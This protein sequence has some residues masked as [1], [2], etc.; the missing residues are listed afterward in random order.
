MRK[1]MVL[2][3]LVFLFL[4]SELLYSSTKLYSIQAPS[5]DVKFKLCNVLYEEDLVTGKIRKIGDLS[6]ANVY[7]VVNFVVNEELGKLFLT[8]YVTY[9]YKV[10]V[11]NLSPLQPIAVLNIETEEPDIELLSNTRNGNLYVTYWDD[12]EE[13]WT[14]KLYYAPDYLK[15]KE[16]DGCFILVKNSYFSD[17]G[18][19][20]FSI[21]NIHG[22]KG[23]FFQVADTTGELI[24][25][26]KCSNLGINNTY[27]IVVGAIRNE[28]LIRSEDKGKYSYYL[29]DP[30]KNLITSKILELNRPLH[31]YCLTY[32]RKI[33]SQ[34][35][36][37][38]IKSF[39]KQITIYDLNRGIEVSRLQLPY[40][41]ILVV[42][43]H[44]EDKIFIKGEVENYMIEEKENKF[45]LSVIGGIFK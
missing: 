6:K 17:D 42:N 16:I 13:M 30:F 31:R 44:A 4:L 11:I 9:K 27:G 40:Q 37:K 43:R 14:T 28:V 29:F 24:I 39:T 26:R 22:E 15:S 35:F 34:E 8:E 38:K 21:C 12:K 7:K 1:K 23:S 19:Y 18:K 10:K 36:D 41:G 3:C 20:L 5:E 45:N 33:I 32:K 2:C 25:T